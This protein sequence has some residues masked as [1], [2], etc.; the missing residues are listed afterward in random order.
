LNYLVIEVI[1]LAAGKNDF[2]EILSKIE[3]YFTKIKD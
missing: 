3:L 2:I 1:I